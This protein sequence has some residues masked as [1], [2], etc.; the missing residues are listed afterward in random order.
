MVVTQ[1]G[2]DDGKLLECATFVALR[3]RYARVSYWR[4]K[5]EV[6]FVVQDSAGRPI[7]IQVSWNGVE[8]RHQRALDEFYET[9]PNATE[10]M[11]ITRHSYADLLGG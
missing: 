2:K 1:T 10:P 7:P 9:F 11:I 3:R 5:G 4:G 6:D 8:E